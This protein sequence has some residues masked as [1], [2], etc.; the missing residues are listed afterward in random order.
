MRLIQPIRCFSAIKFLCDSKE[1]AALYVQKPIFKK[2][3]L[4]DVDGDNKITFPDVHLSQL[5]FPDRANL[6][7]DE[8]E[9]FDDEETPWYE[10]YD[11]DEGLE[12]DLDPEDYEDEDE[13]EEALNQA[14]YQWRDEC[15][16]ASEYGLDPE[17]YETELEYSLALS[18]AKANARVQAESRETPAQNETQPQYNLLFPYE[19][20]DTE[21]EIKEEDYPNKR[22]YLAARY[23]QGYS[24]YL[25][26]AQTGICH[27]IHDY[28]DTILAANYLSYSSGF[29][30]SQAIKDHFELSFSLP[31][32]DEK[33]EFE[34]YEIILKTAKRDIPLSLKIWNWCLE[35][36]MPYQQYDESAAYDM[37]SCVLT[38]LYF[39]PKNYTQNLF[40][41]M[42]TVPSFSQTLLTS[43]CDPAEDIPYLISIAIDDN[44]L[45]IA[46]DLFHST[47]EKYGDN[48]R[49]INALA[50]ETCSYF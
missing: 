17:D 45:T 16:D 4:I 11:T 36:F 28:A 21:K 41:Y 42:E 8:D 22:R 50:R 24:S 29:L 19:S 47:L 49:A 2:R 34:F 31:D 15:K 10:D 37:T 38:Y 43:P 44:F 14:K 1:G 12:Y 33:R 20:D 13:Y 5:L 46:S 35:Q 32:E 18:K 26:N 9:Q 23:L 6:W 40:R 25:T 27:F 30:Y 39:S 3:P 48:W 7:S